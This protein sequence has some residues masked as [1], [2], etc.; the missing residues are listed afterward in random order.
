MS[1]KAMDKDYLLR[2]LHLFEDDVLVQRTIATEE[3]YHGF[4]YYNDKF[5]YKNGNSWENIDTIISLTQQ[6]YNE[7]STAEKNRDVLYWITDA[8]GS[9]L[10]SQGDGINISNNVIST[11]VASAS[12]LGAIK[13]GDGL[14][15][16]ANGVLSSQGEDLGLLVKNGKLCVRH[17]VTEIPSV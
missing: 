7:L 3:G 10:Y 2:Q 5:A 17:E 1:N 12:Q 4:R 6:E 9:G 11:K 14:S 15:I 8:E 13:V 16:D